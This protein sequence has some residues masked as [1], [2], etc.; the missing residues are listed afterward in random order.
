MALICWWGEEE[1]GPRPDSYQPYPGY[2]HLDLC[3]GKTKEL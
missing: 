3:K 2:N 1:Q